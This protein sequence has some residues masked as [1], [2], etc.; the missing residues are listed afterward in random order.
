MR[1]YRVGVGETKNLKIT[2]IMCN[3]NYCKVIMYGD[4]KEEPKKKCYANAVLVNY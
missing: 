3:G 4:S 2:K 1:V